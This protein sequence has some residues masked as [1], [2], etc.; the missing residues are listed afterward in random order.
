MKTQY[1]NY[2]IIM[3]TKIFSDA[4][5]QTCLEGQECNHCQNSLQGDTRLCHFIEEVTEDKKQFESLKDYI[6]YSFVKRDSRRGI[7][8]SN[9]SDEEE[10]L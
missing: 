3:R 1:M 10:D 2:F 8:F 6:G 9:V 4:E 7:V 5:L